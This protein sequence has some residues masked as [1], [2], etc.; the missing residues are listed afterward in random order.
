MKTKLTTVTVETPPQIQDGHIPLKVRF[1]EH[2][3][4]N[5]LLD[6]A[7]SS[8]SE[9]HGEGRLLHD[10]DSHGYS[11]HMLL[12]V[13]Y[14]GMPGAWFVEYTYCDNDGTNVEHVYL[15]AKISVNT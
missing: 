10:T 8:A 14:R 9:M 3:A 12:L 2:N 1:T 5:A 11:R 13:D 15:A 7:C 6:W 4:H